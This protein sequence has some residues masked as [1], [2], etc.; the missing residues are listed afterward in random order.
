MSKRNK[1]PTNIVPLIDSLSVKQQKTMANVIVYAGL[2]YE[3]GLDFRVV[4][5]Q[6]K[7]TTMKGKLKT[8]FTKLEK[9]TSAELN[10]VLD[11]AVI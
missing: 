5:T 3:F 11:I 1:E 4:F 8:V 9:I 2:L 7:N 10:Q 6:A